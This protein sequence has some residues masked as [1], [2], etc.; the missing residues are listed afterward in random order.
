MAALAIYEKYTKEIQDYD[1]D[2]S[3]WLSTWSDSLSGFSLTSDIGITIV[4][5]SRSGNV[6]KVWVSNGTAGNLYNISILGTTTGG[7]VKLAEI[8]IKVR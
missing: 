7:R 2:F 8:S 1:I 6:V 5:S 3:R 4:S